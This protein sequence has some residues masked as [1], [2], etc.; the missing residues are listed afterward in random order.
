MH[1]IPANDVDYGYD[2]YGH[3]LRYLIWETANIPHGASI[4]ISYLEE[5]QYTKYGVPDDDDP[6]YTECYRVPDASI[7]QPVS[8]YR[9]QLGIGQLINFEALSQLPTL[10]VV[11]QVLVVHCEASRAAR[12]GLFGF[13]GDAPIQL[14][15]PLDEARLESFRTFAEQCELEQQDSVKQSFRAENAASMKQRL[16]EVISQQFDVPAL[17]ASM[18]PF[19]MFRLCT[20]MCNGYGRNYVERRDRKEREARLLEQYGP[21]CSECMAQ[22]EGAPCP[23]IGSP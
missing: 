21:R 12:T 6:E 23:F 15:D 16:V 17:A 7:H 20:R 3:P 10:K 22:H 8:P 19:I 5:C 18:R 9:K 2:S 14:V 4:V 13:L 1:W 11:M